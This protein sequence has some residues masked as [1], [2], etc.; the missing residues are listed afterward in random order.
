MKNCA[1]YEE[2]MPISVI[3]LASVYQFCSEFIIL[4]YPGQGVEGKVSLKT[5]AHNYC[6]SAFMLACNDKH[7]VDG[8]QFIQY[9]IK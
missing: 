7:D 1:T 8:N 2:I 5:L 9:S 6:G 3:T 4:S